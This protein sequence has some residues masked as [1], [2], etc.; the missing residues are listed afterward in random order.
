MKPPSLTL[1]SED[2]GPGVASDLAIAP[3]SNF[4]GKTMWLK[5]TVEHSESVSHGRMER[6][7]VTLR[8]RRFGFKV[9]RFTG[10]H[11]K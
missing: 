11:S 3:G 10:D 1:S 8:F 6:S 9:R 5:N 2:G 7:S 4:D